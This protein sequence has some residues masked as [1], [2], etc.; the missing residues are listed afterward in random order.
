MH[1]HDPREWSEIIPCPIHVREIKRTVR[2]TKA[3]LSVPYEILAKAYKKL[4]SNHCRIKQ[5][6]DVTD[7]RLLLSRKRRNEERNVTNNK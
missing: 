4:R 7:V 1:G 2:S 3:L 6:P 5:G